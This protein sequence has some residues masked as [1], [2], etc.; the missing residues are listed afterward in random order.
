MGTNSKIL[1]RLMFEIYW[2]VNNGSQD[3]TQK[4]GHHFLALIDTNFSCHFRHILQFNL[5]NSTSKQTST[6]RIPIGMFIF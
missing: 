1:H 4:L 2:M 5:Q 6:G 3:R